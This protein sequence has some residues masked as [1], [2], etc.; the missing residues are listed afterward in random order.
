VE[1]AAYVLA[2]N[3]CELMI[4]TGFVT[5][6]HWSLSKRLE[7]IVASALAF[8]YAALTRPTFQIIAPAIAGYF[9][10]VTLV[11]HWTAMKWKDATNGSVLLVCTFCALVGGYAVLNYRSF[12]FFG[13]T[14]A[15]GFNLSTKTARFIDRS[16]DDVPMRDKLIIGRNEYL[17]NLPEHSGLEYI[18]SIRHE[19]TKITGLNQR[20][21]SAYMLKLNLLLIQ[22][23]PLTYLQEVV[24]AFG[25]Y[26]FPAANEFANFN[27]R[28]LQLLW[29]VIHFILFGVF[30]LNLILLFGAATYLKMCKV[31]VRA[32]DGVTIGKVRSMEF[33]G[34]VYGLAGTIVVYNAAVSCLVEVGSPR[35]RLPTEGLILF[36]L[37]I[38]AYL[39]WGLVDLC[40]TVL[41]RT[42]PAGGRKV[43]ISERS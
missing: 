5:F 42:Q 18:W 35:H 25:T 30:V 16:P 8:G 13:V 31:F 32:L 17:V 12:G 37:L 22:K 41:E 2:E 3:L 4:V 39:W 43:V 6:I 7:W 15:L 1:S 23:A 21:L 38:G 11:F 19:L 9:L 24:W 27:S 29:A 20:E 10:I 14:P 34:F 40:R 26:L 33:Q 36:M 28:V